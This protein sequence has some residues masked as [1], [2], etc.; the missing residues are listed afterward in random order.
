MKPYSYWFGGARKQ[1]INMNFGIN[2]TLPD[3]SQWCINHHLYI[4]IKK[5]GS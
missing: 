2:D 4:L 5:N 1:N 3:S